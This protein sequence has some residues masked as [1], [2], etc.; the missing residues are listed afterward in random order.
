LTAVANEFA[1]ARVEFSSLK[2]EPQTDELNLLAIARLS[3]FIEL[4][5]PCDRLILS[6]LNINDVNDGSALEWVKQ[7]DR[8]SHNPIQNAPIVMQI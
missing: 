2:P 3:R 7:E 5:N 6:C 1:P 8:F 4:S